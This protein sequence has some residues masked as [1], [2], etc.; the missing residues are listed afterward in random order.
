MEDRIDEGIEWVLMP[1][2][3]TPRSDPEVPQP[4][5]RLASRWLVLV[6]G[7]GSQNILSPQAQEEQ[8]IHSLEGRLQA[9]HGPV[10]AYHEGMSDME[11]VES[12]A[13]PSDP[14][15]DTPDEPDIT[16]NLPRNITLRMALVTLDDI[17]PCA[18]FRQR[19]AVMK[20]VPHIM[21]GP[22]QNALKLALEEATWVNSQ[23]D[24]V[25]QKRGWKLFM[26]LRR[27]LLHRPPGR[28]LIPRSKLVARLEAFSRG[29]WIQLLTASAVCDE[30]AAIRQSRRRGGD[31]V[32]RR[33][34]KAERLVHV[35]ELS[36]ARQALE[37]S[38][39]APGTRS[40]LDQLQDRQRRPPNPRE[41][42]PRE[43]LEHQLL[44]PV[45]L[46]EKIFGRNLR[47][48]RRGVTGGPSGMTCEHLRP[49]LNKVRSMHLL[50]R[51]GE[52]LARA[53]VPPFV[54][55]LVRCGRMT[56]LAKPDGGVRGIVSGDVLR[57]LV[58]RTMAKQLGPSVKAATS[59]HQHVLA[60]RAGCECIAHVL[61]GL[62]DLNPE[63]TVTSIDG[64]SACYLISQRT[65]AVLPYFSCAC[66]MVPSEYLWEDDSGVTHSIPQGEGGEQGDAMMPLL[67]CLG[68]HGPQWFEGW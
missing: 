21:C 65:V 55:P 33:V 49:L 20:N 45:V 34:M 67:F 2:P 32:E 15:G 53:H 47:S 7:R 3:V 31:D 44:A 25:R 61:Q 42:L 66:S 17:D 10:D 30:Q 54:V 63:T 14:V 60:T 56:A 23:Q 16:A 22:F 48:A 6:G 35:G 38:E 40:T 41:P 24:E 8:T 43:I 46:D 51:L 29:E 57:R 13:G 19:A 62:C 50:Y 68:Q 27:M 26:L 12:V 64:V 18:V 9:A 28:G 5:Q 11:S 52:N 37:G 39:L 36:S 58:A 1:D 4:C 59:P